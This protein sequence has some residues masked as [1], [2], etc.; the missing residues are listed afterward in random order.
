MIRRG[1]RRLAIIVAVL[2]VSTTLVS[3]AVGLAAGAGALR[4]LSLG[5]MLVGS[6]IFIAGAALGL[7]GSVRPERRLDGTVVGVKVDRAEGMETLNA[8]VLFV[9][10]GLLLVLVGVLLHPHLRLV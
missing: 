5:F 9:G 8:S 3:L 10:L 4:A 1:L 6:F 2:F 7:R